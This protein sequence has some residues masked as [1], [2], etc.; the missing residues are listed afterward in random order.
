MSK[1]CIKSIA[2]L[3]LI[4]YLLGLYIINHLCHLGFR[5]RLSFLVILTILMRLKKLLRIQTSY[6]FPTDLQLL[7]NHLV[8]FYFLKKI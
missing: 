1:N 4:Y 3:V 6:N 8:D 2:L 7:L 5:Y